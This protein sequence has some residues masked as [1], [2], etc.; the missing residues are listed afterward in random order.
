MSFVLNLGYGVHRAEVKSIELVWLV[1]LR[2]TK[3]A[4]IP[5]RGWLPKAIR[6]PTPTSALV[7]R[8][9]LVTAGLVLLMTYSEVVSRGVFLTAIITVGLVTMLV[10]R[11]SALGEVRVKKLVAYRTLSQ[12][13]LG[14]ITYGLGQ[15]YVGYLNLVA[16]GFAKRLLF[17]Q[18]G[19]L[20]HNGMNQQEVRKWSA[21][22]QVEGAMRVQLVSSLFSL[23][24]LAFY[25]GIVRKEVIL[26]SINRRGWYIGL[27][28][29][30]TFSIYLTLVYSFIIYKRLFHSRVQPLMLHHARVTMLFVTLVE[31][32]AVVCYF[33]WLGLNIGSLPRGFRYVEVY[34]PIVI[35]GGAVGRYRFVGNMG[36]YKRLLGLTYVFGNSQHYKWAQGALLNLKFFESFMYFGNIVVSMVL[37]LS[38]IKLLRLNIGKSNH[39]LMFLVV[40]LVLLL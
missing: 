22:G 38:S 31:V 10:G 17:I 36:T 7:H 25:R 23:C 13:G 12:I 32:G 5:F 37:S 3:S 30:I 18:V 15:F 8:S 2:F 27:L 39:M 29:C 16:H 21:V 24:G 28:L 35:L 20:I 40:T 4:Q 6:A 9:T 14:I 19:Y 33:R 1:L 11:L 34:V 26:E